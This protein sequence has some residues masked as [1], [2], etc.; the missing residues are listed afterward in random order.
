MPLILAGDRSAAAIRGIATAP[1]KVN[2][3]ALSLAATIGLAST[4]RSLIPGRSRQHFGCW[5]V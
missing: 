2:G 3:T 5:A 1:P 4:I